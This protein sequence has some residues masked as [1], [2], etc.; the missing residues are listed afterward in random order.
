MDDIARALQRPFKKNELHSRPGGGG[1]ELIY[2]T[3]RTAM[4]RLD[5]VF[6]PAGWQ[7][8]YAFHGERTMCTVSCFIKGEWVSKTDGAGDTSIEGEKGGISDSFKRACVAWGIA[9]YLY[10]PRSFPEG[11]NGKPARWATQQG[12]DEIWAERDAQGIE[13]FRNALGRAA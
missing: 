6:T 7:V 9:R 10:N 12:Y 13:E 5:E 11:L 4:D 3:A 1:K 8:S 2:I